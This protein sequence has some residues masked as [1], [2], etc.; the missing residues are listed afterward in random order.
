MEYAQKTWN[1]CFHISLCLEDDQNPVESFDLETKEIRLEEAEKI[2]ETL[3][4]TVHVANKPCKEK[5][6]NL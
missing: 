3:F 5:E 2:M 6:S 4:L 1:R